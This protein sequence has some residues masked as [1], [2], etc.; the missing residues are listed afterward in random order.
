MATVASSFLDDFTSTLPKDEE[1]DDFVV[2]TEGKSGAGSTAVTDEATSKD[3]TTDTQD[4]LKS[5]TS[6]SDQ[7]GSTTPAVT[8]ETTA[9]AEDQAEE[10]SPISTAQSALDRLLSQIRSR[11][12]E[13]QQAVVS[14]LESAAPKLATGTE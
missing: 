7:A 8:K 2:S 13:A 3:T 14:D 9:V 5:F 1:E 11:A 10:G 6:S 12:E 4:F